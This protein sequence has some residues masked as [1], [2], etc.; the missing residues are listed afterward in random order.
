MI[1]KKIFYLII[2]TSAML[3]TACGNGGTV[4]EEDDSIFI[5]RTDTSPADHTN[6]Y[7]DSTKLKKEIKDD[8]I[9][10]GKP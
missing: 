4:P 2:T 6:T 3:I 1:F 5:Q 10:I 8:S 7:L 9:T